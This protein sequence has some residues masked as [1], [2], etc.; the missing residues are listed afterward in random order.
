VGDAASTLLARARRR[1]IGLALL[2]A[3]VAACSGGPRGRVQE[4][5]VQ[6]GR[7]PPPTATPRPLPQPT[8][9]PDCTDPPVQIVGYTLEGPASAD[10]RTIV[11]QLKTTC[12]APV[13]V[14]LSA[15][16]LDG[17]GAVRAARAFVTLRR[18]QPGEVRPFREV[19]HG[20]RGATRV[21]LSAD[22]QR[23]RIRR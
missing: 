5:P 14:T 4:L 21:E 18:V 11:G 9:T 6:L 13:D 17:S 16:W 19:A 7:E 1:A 2:A 15:R 3:L 10:S 12:Q 23:S 8:P 22:V 20:G